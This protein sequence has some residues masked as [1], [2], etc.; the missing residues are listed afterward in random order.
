MYK[1]SLSFE[2]TLRSALSSGLEPGMPPGR[3]HTARGMCW[4]G[5]HLM[6]VCLIAMFSIAMY[7]AIVWGS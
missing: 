3:F 5:M 7:W 2:S 4:I 1:V 6:D